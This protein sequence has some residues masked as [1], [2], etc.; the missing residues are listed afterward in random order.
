LLKLKQDEGLYREMPGAVTMGA[1]RAGMQA[2]AADLPIPSRLSPGDY[3]MEVHA[4]KDGR[5]VFTASRAMDVE[6]VGIPS[7][8]ADLAFNHGAWY[9]VLASVIAIS[10]P[11]SASA[12]SSS[13]R[14]LT[15][16]PCGRPWSGTFPAVGQKAL[17]ALF[18]ALQ[19]FKSILERNNAILELMATLGDKL[20][21]D[22]VYRPAVS[23]RYCERLGDQVFKLISDLSLLCQRKNVALFTAFERIRSDTGRAG[24]RRALSRPDHNP[25]PGELTHDLADEGGNKMAGLGDIR[26]I[27]GFAVPEGFVITAGA[28]SRS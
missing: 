19:E 25:A 24:G 26:N 11:D 2:F 18:G 23:L 14:R 16:I 6:M 4:L 12:W 28:I 7:M 8:M 9:G 3:A 17:R 13:A 1:A 20:G 5:E 27:L 22:Y 10:W 15:N 21:G